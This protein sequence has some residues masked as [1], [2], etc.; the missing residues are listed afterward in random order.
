MHFQLAQLYQEATWDAM[1]LPRKFYIKYRGF[2]PTHGRHDLP[3]FRNLFLRAAL[4]CAVR[5]AP[6]PPRTP[7]EL[8]G[9]ATSSPGVAESSLGDAKS[10]LGDATS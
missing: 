8:L 9:D 5:C 4:A 2:G 6:R 7:V 3:A 10:S 1:K